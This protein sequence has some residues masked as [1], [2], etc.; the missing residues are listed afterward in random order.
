MVLD[1]AP[2]DRARLLNHVAMT[3]SKVQGRFPGLTPGRVTS[4]LRCCICNPLVGGSPCSLHLLGK[5]I[6]F[7]WEV[8]IG[9]TKNHFVDLGDGLRGYQIDLFHIHVGVY[10]A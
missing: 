4:F 9:G 10:V 2:M 5:A 8:P 6:D 3:W 1:M 7:R